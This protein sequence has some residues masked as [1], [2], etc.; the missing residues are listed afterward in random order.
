MNI[1]TTKRILQYAA[2]LSAV[3]TAMS[4]AAAEDG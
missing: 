2:L 3:G 1:R 4:T